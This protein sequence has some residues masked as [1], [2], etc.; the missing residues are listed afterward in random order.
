[1][2]NIAEVMNILRNTVCFTNLDQ[3]SVIIIRFSLPRSMK[4]T[5]ARIKIRRS[6]HRFSALSR[7][8][9]SRLLV[10]ELCKDFAH[11]VGVEQNKPDNIVSFNDSFF[12]NAHMLGRFKFQTFAILELVKK[13]SWERVVNSTLKY[14]ILIL[15]FHDTLFA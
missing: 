10:D 15:I 4:H 5:A 13:I 7:I 12:L 8:V 1:M 9:T 11:F 2:L 6:P 3:G 14:H